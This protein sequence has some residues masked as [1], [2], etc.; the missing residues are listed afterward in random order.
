MDIEVKD[1]I[2]I[3]EHTTMSTHQLIDLSLINQVLNVYI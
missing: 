1:K 2:D 3:Y